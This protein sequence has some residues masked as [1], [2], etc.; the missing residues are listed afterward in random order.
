M[1]RIFLFL[2]FSVEYEPQSFVLSDG[3]TYCP[4]FLLHETGELIEVKGRWIKD[5]K[6]RFDLFKKE[7]P[8]LSIEIIG[9]KKYSKYLSDFKTAVPNLEK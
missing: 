5:A 4:D 1:L 3:T 7:Y 2:G 6:R 8:G 9:P